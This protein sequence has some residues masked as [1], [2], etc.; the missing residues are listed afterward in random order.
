MSRIASII[1]PPSRHAI[2]G[3]HKLT[4]KLQMA[5]AVIDSA[6]GKDFFRLRRDRLMHRFGLDKVYWIN[7]SVITRTLPKAHDSFIL[8]ADFT[9]RTVAFES[10]RTFVFIDEILRKG[11]SP[12][13]TT[14]YHQLARGG[15]IKRYVDR[16]GTAV[17]SE[18]ASADAFADYHE[19]CKRM[20]DHIAK[21]GVID[22]NSERARAD[23]YDT[24]SDENIGVAVDPKGQLVHYRKGHHRLAISKVLSLPVVPVSLQ[25]ISGIYLSRFI[26][27]PYALTPNRLISAMND[28]VASAMRV[29]S[30]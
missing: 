15:A 14:L 11:R 4:N 9:P 27:K 16:G 30:S 28:A 3:L 12:M 23:L 17:R 2:A 29:A 1:K 8:F 21:H 13:E 5:E 26:D 24:K 19:R 20:A 22:V 18:V 6:L 10:H 7:P 25:L